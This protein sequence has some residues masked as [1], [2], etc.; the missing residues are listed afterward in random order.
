MGLV[1][2]SWGHKSKGNGMWTSGRTQVSSDIKPL[3]LRLLQR[4]AS[5]VTFAVLQA[6][7]G[8]VDRAILSETLASALGMLSHVDSAGGS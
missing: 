3:Y 2:S 5:L 8:K 1:G 7:A 6:S 4:H